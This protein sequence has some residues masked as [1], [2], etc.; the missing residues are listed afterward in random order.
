MSYKFSIPTF[1]KTVIKT[2]GEYV[3]TY[4]GSHDCMLLCNE[5]GI[6]A[7]SEEY[8]NS[9]R[10]K[11]LMD[12]GSP[13]Y[14]LSI[15]DDTFRPKPHLKKFKTEQEVID[16]RCQVDKWMWNRFKLGLAELLDKEADSVLKVL[17]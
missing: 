13:K 16:Y 4:P 2:F 15:E 9:G 11:R 5:D 12:N 7:Y 17:D 10:V 1:R 14:Y 6:F 8:V 3:R